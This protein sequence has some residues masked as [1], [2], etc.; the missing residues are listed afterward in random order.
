MDKVPNIV[1]PPPGPKSRALLEKRNDLI[2]PGVYLVQPITIAESK[3][4]VMKDVD[5]NVYIDNLLLI[6]LNCPEEVELAKELCRIHPWARMVRFARTG[7]EAEAGAVRIARAER[8]KDKI[9]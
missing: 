1:T 5:G 6:G 8:K 7:G 4:A 9:F 2:P 3:G